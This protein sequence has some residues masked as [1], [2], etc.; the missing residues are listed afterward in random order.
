[1]KAVLFAAG[2]GTRLYPHTLDKPKAL[3]SI[4][5]RPMLYRVMDKLYEA[6]IREYVVNVHAFA[7]QVEKALELYALSKPGISFDISDERDLL[8]ETGGGLKKMAAFLKDG[9]FLVHNVDVLSDI[10]LKLFMEQALGLLSVPFQSQTQARPQLRAQTRPQPRV[11]ARFQSQVVPPQS[12]VV[13]P[14]SQVQPQTQDQL[15]TGGQYPLAVLA[16]RNDF[17]NRCFLLNQH[18]LLCGWENKRSGEQIISRQQEALHPV[19]FMGIH[20]ISPSIFPLMEEE[21]VFSIIDVYLRL[22]RQH[23]ILGLDQSACKWMDIGSPEQLLL[24]EKQL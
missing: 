17:K 23:I 21:G 5:G 9:P 20:C 22:A 18:N 13:P 6:G 10:D 8:L 16:V 19:G 15:Q 4:Q 14:Q 24:A 12:Q 11:Q 3:V 2:L 7:G 1:M